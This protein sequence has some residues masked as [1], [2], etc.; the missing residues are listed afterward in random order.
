MAGG[1][2]PQQ[3]HLD[4]VVPSKE[5]LEIQHQRALELGARVLHDGSDEEEE[6]IYIY[7]DPAGHPFCIFVLPEA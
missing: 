1:Q 3:A 4:F 6:P 7:A 2:D 5:E